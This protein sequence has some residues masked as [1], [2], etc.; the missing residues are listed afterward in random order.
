MWR[1]LTVC[2]CFLDGCKLWRIKK[3]NYKLQISKKKIKTKKQPL[4]T[5]SSPRVA[6]TKT[7]RL[8]DSTDSIEHKPTII[9]ERR[10]HCS[11]THTLHSITKP[12]ENC[13][14]F[15]LLWQILLLLVAA[16]GGFLGSLEEIVCVCVCVSR[17]A[18]AAH[19]SH[20]SYST[21]WGT[22]TK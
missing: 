8:G 4:H 16:G 13:S 22:F 10:D 3:P 11:I 1:L 17:C 18:L 9:T 20:Y 12:H 6:A 15:V 5:Y 19:A 2:D 7:A 21:R 14:I